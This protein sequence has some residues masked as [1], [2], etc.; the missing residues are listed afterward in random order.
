[1]GALRVFLLALG[2]LAAS[3][4]MHILDRK[5]VVQI[6]DFIIE[7]TDIAAFSLT[8]VSFIGA[9]FWGMKKLG[10]D[11]YASNNLQPDEHG[12]RYGRLPSRVLFSTSGFGA[13]LLFCAIFLSEPLPTNFTTA[14]IWLCPAFFFL[15]V[16][17]YLQLWFYGYDE[18]TLF[19]RNWRFKVDRHGW[20]ELD[21]TADK[22]GSYV[23]KFNQSGNAQIPDSAQG[24][25]ELRKFVEKRLN[26]A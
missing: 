23:I 6:P 8:L 18:D 12:T 1:M 4:G 20:D 9:L 26:N 7:T 2:L 24:L 5:D 25:P 19:I 21:S 14:V 3:L 13:F 22:W 17:L 15:Y 11:Q 16:G 10:F